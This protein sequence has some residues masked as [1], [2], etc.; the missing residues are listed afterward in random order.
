[1]SRLAVKRFMFIAI[2]IFVQ[3]SLLR[4]ALINLALLCGQ[5]GGEGNGISPLRGQNN[6]QGCSDVGCL[7]NV[8]P[9]YE[10]VDEVEAHDR[11]STAWNTEL[12]FEKGLQSTA[13][14]E[15]MLT[16]AIDTMYVVGE[17]PLL[18]DPFLAHATEAFEKLSFLVVQDIFMH[19]TAEIADVVLPAA[20]FAEKDGTFT[21]S[22]RRVQ[23]VRKI[24]NAP[25]GAREDWKI[26][27]ELAR[28]ILTI[29]GRSTEGFSHESASDIFDDMSSLMPIIG[30]LSHERLDREGGI[31]WPCP[32]H[33]HP[34]T[35]RLFTEEFPR[36]RG[37]FVGVRQGPPSAELPSKRFP[38]TLITGRTLYHWHG[39]VIT[40]RVKG[41]VDMVPVVTV[42]INI[43]DAIQL[44]L[45]DGDDVQLAS[46]RGEII[47]QVQTGKRQR[48]GELFVPFVQLEGVAANFL[49]N[50]ELDTLA[51]IP[52][53]KA[54]AVR[55]ESPGTPPRRG[56]KRALKKHF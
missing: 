9:G 2:F 17:N 13:M 50:D 51:G 10:A 19:E 53:Y 42:D 35:S 29:L 46:R 25:G 23:L 8:F 38:F 5:V 56:K 11:W 28:R 52:E 4:S 18:S 32:D 55:I 33:N 47:A 44:G 3:F 37:K 30:G 6:V 15:S 34:G 49:T 43:D 26:I 54:C 45:Q 12:T 1:M 16:G 21:N 20:A 41:L 22:E 48:R 24:V 27:S 36:G 14:I 7:P 40:R 39:G 31:Q